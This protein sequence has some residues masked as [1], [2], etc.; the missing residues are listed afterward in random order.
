MALVV[1]GAIGVGFILLALMEHPEA[2]A[3]MASEKELISGVIEARRIEARQLVTH[4]VI[5]ISGVDVEVPAHMFDRFHEGQSVR[6][7][8]TSDK[9]EF[10]SLVATSSEADDVP[11]V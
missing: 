11:S 2:K 10:L 1:L 7:E 4:H 3:E 8:R 9:G 6:A 5:R